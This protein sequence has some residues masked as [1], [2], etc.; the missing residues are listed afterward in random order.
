M[1]LTALILVVL[2]VSA[3]ILLWP[4]KAAV[5][6][7]K[8]VYEWLVLLDPHVS[9]TASHE[10]ARLALVA[11]G[12]AALPELEKLLSEKPGGVSERVRNYL[13]RFRLLRPR[14]LTLHQQE[15]RA[16]RAAYILA[17]DASI[18]IRRL[19]PHLVWWYTNSNYAVSENTRALA[20]AGSEGIA[21]LTNLACSHP[22]RYVRDDAA[23]A[24]HLVPNAP[25]TAEALLRIATS[26][27]DQQLRA[28][29]FSYLP[30]T[31]GPTNLSCPLP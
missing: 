14:P 11:M 20:R 25:G 4:K 26:E 5:Y 6:Q 2:V 16:S 1:P 21:V 9:Q 10:Q 24:L 30:R 15:H 19:I 7:G 22:V 31:R 18:D 12:K 27:P 28:D 17:E 3:A 23:W 29:A 13:V 8:T